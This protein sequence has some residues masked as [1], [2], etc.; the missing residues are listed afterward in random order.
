MPPADRFR[1]MK[2]YFWAED[3]KLESTYDL[4]WEQLYFCYYQTLEQICQML[5]MYSQSS[6]LPCGSHCPFCF[7]N[8]YFL[9][10]CNTISHVLF[11]F[12][13]CTTVPFICDMIAYMYGLICW[14]SK[15][16]SLSLCLS[17]RNTYKPIPIP[18]AIPIPM[19]NGAK[20][21]LSSMGC[22]RIS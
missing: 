16:D 20:G 4:I 22:Q 13:L 3:S 5:R 21:R 12:S 6:N 18:I 9:C 10:S 1:M 15:P 8:V 17:A 19:A 2:S 14:E 7:K 11:S